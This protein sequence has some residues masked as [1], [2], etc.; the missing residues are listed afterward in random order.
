[1]SGDSYVAVPPDSTVT[2]AHKIDTTQVVRPDNASSPA[3]VWTQVER[4][5]ITM[6]DD[7]NI[8]QLQARLLHEIVHE[9]QQLRMS[10]L[11]AFH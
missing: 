11:N 3:T 1:M 6:G 5:R 10:L 9:L 2:G 4:Q 7:D 8:Q